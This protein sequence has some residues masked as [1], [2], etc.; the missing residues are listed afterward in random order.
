MSAKITY[1]AILLAVMGIATVQMMSILSIQSAEAQTA[2]QG[3]CIKD[4]IGGT[5]ERTKQ[6]CKEVIID[7]QGECMQAVR[8]GT[9]G[10]PE[11]YCKEAYP[12]KQHPHL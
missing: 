12:A 4:E 5:I 6:I 8:E 7:N 10:L 2:N 11:E 1:A 3:Q 9:V